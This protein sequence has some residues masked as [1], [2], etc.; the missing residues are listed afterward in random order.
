MKQLNRITPQAS[1]HW[2][3]DGFPVRNLISIPRDAEHASPFLMLDFAGP[4]HFAPASVPRG[5]GAHPH[6]GFE[7]V[8]IV[9]Q[10]EVAHRDTT[11][12]SGVIGPGDVQWMTA[13]AGV[14][15]DEFH[16]PAFSR[17]GGTLEMAQLWVNLPA[18]DKLGEP[19]YQAIGAAQIPEIVLPEN[20]GSL[21]VIAGEYAGAQGPTRTRSPMHVW[22][23]RLNAGSHVAFTL[24]EGWTTLL[25]VLRGEVT[26]GGKR[27]QTAQTGHFSRSGTGLAVT[28][29]QDSQ[30]LLL[31][32][33]PLN[34]PIA[35]YGPFVMNTKQEL[36]AA[37]EDFNSGRFGRLADQSARM[38]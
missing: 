9:Y 3:G 16:S 2:V 19:A 28:V 34:E 25:V 13:A 18:R 5:V 22:D 24:P 35:H 4:Q 7:T 38:R 1:A 12:N 15:H 27:I 36:V 26:V 10:G 31:S 32:G 17:E 23:L 6:R 37:I 30:V 20:A 11:G 8:T 14:L 29:G 33:A 21:R